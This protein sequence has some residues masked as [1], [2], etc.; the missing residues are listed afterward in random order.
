MIVKTG[1]TDT[2]W[3]MMTRFTTTQMQ[4]YYPPTGEVGLEP[5]MSGDHAQQSIYPPGDRRLRGPTQ[6]SQLNV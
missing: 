5:H 3:N 4:S 2:W 6:A 1:T